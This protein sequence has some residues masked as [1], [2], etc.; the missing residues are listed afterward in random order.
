MSLR[1]SDVELIPDFPQPRRAYP[2][3]NTFV[4]DCWPL[5][6][7]RD[8]GTATE[9]EV[10]KFRQCNNIA[11]ASACVNTDGCTW[12]KRNAARAMQHPSSYDEKLDAFDGCM[13]REQLPFWSRQWE[14]LRRRDAS[15]SASVLVE[16]GGKESFYFK[17]QR[18]IDSLRKMIELSQGERQ[19][20]S[21]ED[22][23]GH[24]KIIRNYLNARE[25]GQVGYDPD[26]TKTAYHLNKLLASK[27]REFENVWG[28]N[29]L[30]IGTPKTTKS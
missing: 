1:I 27:Y 4:P 23:E 12:K 15:K 11:D 30:P 25:N 20:L 13:P 10:S 29:R 17:R 24:V 5:R 28:L 14:K 8:G 22:V 21:K 2:E 26:Q 16:Q 7:T 6:A 19:Y 18:S 3:I 9:R